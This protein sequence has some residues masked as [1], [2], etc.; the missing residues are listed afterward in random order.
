MKAQPWKKGDKFSASHLNQM[1]DATNAANL[2]TP[3]GGLAKFRNGSLLQLDEETYCVD[4]RFGVIVNQGPDSATDHFDC[5]Y[6]VKFLYV[7]DGGLRDNLTL[8]ISPPPED[9][10][11][12]SE[13]HP[14]TVINLAEYSEN[15]HFLRNDSSKSVI[16]YGFLD[17]SSM[18]KH[19]VMWVPPEKLLGKI[20]LVGPASEDDFTDNRYWVKLQ[21][22]S[23]TGSTYSD[24]L[25]TTDREIAANPANPGKSASTDGFTNDNDILVIAATN[26][27]EPSGSHLVR[28]QLV[29]LSYG[30]DQTVSDHPIPNLRYWFT[31]SPP[32]LIPVLVE[33]DGGSDGTKTTTASWTYTISSL[34]G[35]SIATEVVLTK[36]RPK[37]T[38]VPGTGYGLIFYDGTSIVLWDAGELYGTGGC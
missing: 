35:I 2:S 13:P 31:M 22:I 24:L 34:D 9:T 33:T 16:I 10:D 8:V 7:D 5:R 4:I 6:F 28:Q 29:E 37:G 30:L 23:N 36:G 18:Q 3:I 32:Q 15:T 12:P 26:L 38:A 25:T 14:P 27:A 1:V 21:S 20:V 19:W 11:G 17:Y